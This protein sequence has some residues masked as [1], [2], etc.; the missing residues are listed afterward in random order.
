MKF[1]ESFLGKMYS[2]DS[3]G[4]CDRHEKPVPPFLAIFQE[5]IGPGQGLHLR[6]VVIISRG[7]ISPE[8]NPATFLK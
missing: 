7:C 5:R 3:R 1:I 2:L 8:F 6:H 4:G